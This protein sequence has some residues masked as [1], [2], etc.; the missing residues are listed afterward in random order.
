[1]DTNKDTLVCL[2]DV[3]GF[4]NLFERHGIDA[5]ETMYK[6]LISIVE[7]KILV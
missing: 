7:E 2:L 4:E 6:E 3:L 5:I 1:M